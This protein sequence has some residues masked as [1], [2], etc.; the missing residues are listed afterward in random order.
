MRPYGWREDAARQ[1]C[2]HTG[3]L[4]MII[5]SIPPKKSIGLFYLKHKDRL[6]GIEHPMVKDI[7]AVLQGEKVKG[8]PSM[9]DI[10]DRTEMYGIEL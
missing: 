1:S 5:E 7:L 2:N 8:Y 10:E 9:E 3:I 4:V 6:E